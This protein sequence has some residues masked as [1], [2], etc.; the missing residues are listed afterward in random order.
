MAER[1]ESIAVARKGRPPIY[2][3][4]EWMDGSAWRIRRGKDFSVLPD[5]MAR[6]VRQR[7]RRYGVPVVV[8]VDNAAGSVE[9]QFAGPES[10]AA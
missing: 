1:I 8:T 10:E 4:S 9:F 7:A 6:G 5:N 3:W 2:P